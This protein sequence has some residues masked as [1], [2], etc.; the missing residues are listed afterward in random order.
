MA[1]AWPRCPAGI[2]TVATRAFSCAGDCATLTRRD[3]KSAPS[4]WV[5]TRNSMP[6]PARPW[7]GRAATPNAIRTRSVEAVVPNTNRAGVLASSTESPSDAR[8]SPAA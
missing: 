4:G 8:A 1:T 3:H 6:S 2:G 5:E 7:L